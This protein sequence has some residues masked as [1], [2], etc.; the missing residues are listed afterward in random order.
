MSDKKVND[1]TLKHTSPNGRTEQSLPPCVR[2]LSY[3]KNILTPRAIKSN[4]DGIKNQAGRHLSATQAS[5]QSL[6][7]TECTSNSYTQ[8]RELS[9]L[10]K[11]PGSGK[12]TYNLVLL[13]GG[14]WY[15]SDGLSWAARWTAGECCVVLHG[16]TSAGATAHQ[17]V[18]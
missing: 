18:V 14:V 9:D 7:E 13:H 17:G 8:G 3:G 10:I 16:E 5:I 12:L 4:K 2:L 11:V 1:T 6:R 15:C